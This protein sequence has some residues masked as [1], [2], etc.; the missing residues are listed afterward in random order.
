MTNGLE[1]QDKKL[2]ADIAALDDDT[3]RQV[4]LA[5]ARQ[6][7]ELNEVTGAV[8]EEALAAAEAGAFGDTDLIGRLSAFADDIEVPYMKALDRDIVDEP[9]LVLFRKARAVTALYLALD[10]DI[11]AQAGNSVYEALFA[12]VA[13]ESVRALLPA[14]AKP[15]KK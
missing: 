4:V 3:L 14:A 12:D 15:P 2:A 5:T 10:G 6:A 9:V 11:R 8:I 13:P 1:F 7:L